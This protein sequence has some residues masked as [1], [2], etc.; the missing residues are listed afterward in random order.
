MSGAHANEEACPTEVTNFKSRV[1]E[2][3]LPD[4]PENVYD[5]TGGFVGGTF[6]C[7]GGFK[8][9]AETVTDKIYE[10]G[11]PTA[12]A[13]MIKKREAAASCVV[14][15]KLWITGGENETDDGLRST[16]MFDPKSGTVEPG[17]DLPVA[18]SNHSICYVESISTAILSGGEYYRDKTWFYNF[19]NPEQGWVPGPRLNQGRLGHVCGAIKDSSD[20]NKTIVVVVGGL[21]QKS[22]EI[23]V[24]D[25]LS[26]E[27]EKKWVQGP[28]LPFRIW[29]GAGVITP[30]GKSFLFLGGLNYDKN[31]REDCIYKLQCYNL[32]CEWKKMDKKLKV[33]RRSHVADFVPDSV[34]ESLLKQNQNVHGQIDNDNLS[35]MRLNKTFS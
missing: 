27:E 34:L 12:V 6:V 17:P 3:N 15:N 1:N 8:R 11:S 35:P 31:Q 4:H 13:T 19:E 2:Y 23:L 14:G 5:A 20:E 33:A 9:T 29:D 26:E 16:D 22:T 21:R 18:T 10:T 30:D 28:D 25:S 7:A 24:I 32:K